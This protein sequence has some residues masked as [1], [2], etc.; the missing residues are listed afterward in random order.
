ME[1]PADLKGRRVGVPEDRMTAA[2]RLRGLMKDDFG[3]RAV[4]VH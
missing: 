1:S 2:L 3:V 4:D